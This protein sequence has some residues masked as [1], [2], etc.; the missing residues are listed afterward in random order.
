MLLLNLL[1]LP[2]KLAVKLLLYSVGAVF[3]LF[4]AMLTLLNGIFS[5][6]FKF[7]G[8]I[9]I[10]M[11]IVSVIFSPLIGGFSRIDYISVIVMTVFMLLV[12]LAPEAVQLILN[13]LCSIAFALFNG[14]SF[15]LF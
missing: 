4:F 3:I 7:V 5:G 2:L 12:M 14:A 15:K 10:L 1:L 9:I 13:G 11:C 8:T 6:L